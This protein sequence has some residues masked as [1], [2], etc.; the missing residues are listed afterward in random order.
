MPLEPPKTAQEPRE[1][2]DAVEGLTERRSFFLDDLTISIILVAVV[3]LGLWY[4]A[5]AA[6]ISWLFG[7]GWSEP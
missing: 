4:W 7:A 5:T 2:S 3:G 6:A 1:S